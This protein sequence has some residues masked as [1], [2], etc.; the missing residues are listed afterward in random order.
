MQFRAGFGDSRRYAAP[1]QRCFPFTEKVFFQGWDQVFP[2][3]I[4]DFC[5]DLFCFGAG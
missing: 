1:A 4:G 5:A 3:D 2:E